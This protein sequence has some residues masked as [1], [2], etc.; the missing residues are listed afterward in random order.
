[1]D[2]R[3][4]QLLDFAKMQLEDLKIKPRLLEIDLIIKEVASRFLVLFQNKEQSLKLEIPDSLPQ[5]KAD[6]EK[7]EQ[8]LVNLLSNANK[9]SPTG[10]NIT[11]RVREDGNR[12]VVEVKDS[13][14]AIP[15][16][17]KV[18]LFDPYY[19]GEDADKRQRFPGLGL[20][21]AISRKLVE[22][23]QGE[24]WVDSKSRKGNTFAFSLPTLEQRAKGIG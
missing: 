13:A 23:H 8:I 3:V 22:L 17:E 7:L 19:R 16:E 20:G 21:L 1:M 15:E 5:V 14:P 11:L 9:F 6:R 2:G 10:G 24:I 4:T 12:I 18:K